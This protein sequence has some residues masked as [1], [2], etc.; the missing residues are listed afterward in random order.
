MIG[1]EEVSKPSS[2]IKVI[3]APIVDV[4]SWLGSTLMPSVA[5][6]GL[7]VAGLGMLLMF[8]ALVFMVKNLRGALLRHMDGLFRTY[9]FRTDARAYGIGLVSTVLVQSSSITSSLMV[10]LAGLA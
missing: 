4:A 6:A 5:A 7:F 8:T 2:P 9:F 1:L 3:T 10:P